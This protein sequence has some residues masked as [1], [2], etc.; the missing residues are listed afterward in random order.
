MTAVNGHF[1]VISNWRSLATPFT[2]HTPSIPDLCDN[3]LP[4]LLSF[5][6]LMTNSLFEAIKQRMEKDVD[7]VG[8]V[9]RLVKSK[10]EE[11]DREVKSLAAFVQVDCWIKITNLVFL[12]VAE[13]SK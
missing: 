9:A 4:F 10:I 8:K 2:T 3:A 11:L 13:F 6:R 5:L 7:E 12:L 1:C